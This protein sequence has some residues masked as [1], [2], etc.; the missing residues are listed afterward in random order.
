MYAV[1]LVLCKVATNS[2]RSVQVL[3]ATGELTYLHLQEVTINNPFTAEVT[4]NNPFTAAKK[5]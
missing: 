3:Q 4:I 5:Y 1:L 2:E